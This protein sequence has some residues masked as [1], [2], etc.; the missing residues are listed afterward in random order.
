MN[1]EWDGAPICDQIPFTQMRGLWKAQKF[2]IQDWTGAHIDMWSKKM[3]IIENIFAPNLRD[4]KCFPRVY[5]TSMNNLHGGAPWWVGSKY[6]QAARK[7]Q[8]WTHPEQRK[9]NS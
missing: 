5:N 4:S 2:Y 9:V 8:A 7:D 3:V 6:D 1:K